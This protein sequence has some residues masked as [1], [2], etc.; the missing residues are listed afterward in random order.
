MGNENNNEQTIGNNTEKKKY[1]S[2]GNNCYRHCSP[3]SSKD[4][5]G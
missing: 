1:I 5:L 3:A 4:M 2:F